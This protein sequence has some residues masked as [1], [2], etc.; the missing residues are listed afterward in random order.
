MSAPVSVREAIARLQAFDR[1][2]LRQATERAFYR[3]LDVGRRSAVSTL[4][5]STIGSMVERRGH[6]QLHLGRSSKKRFTA[7]QMLGLRESTI[8][9][10]VRRMPVERGIS[11]V[12]VSYRAGLE[13]TGFAALIE[14]GGRTKSHQI[15]RIRL[16]GYSRKRATRQRQVEALPPMTFQ[17]G[18]KWVSKRI[19][20]HPGSKVPRNPFLASGASAAQRALPTLYERSLAEELAKARL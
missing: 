20:T 7:S 9:L 6:V 19:V 14:S 11:G 12:S 3:S 2:G 10:I 16:G 4:K 15:K 13:T 18:G 17:I 1:V 5:R 8:P